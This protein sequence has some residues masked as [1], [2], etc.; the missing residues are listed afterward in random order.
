MYDLER[1]DRIIEILKEKNSISVNKLANILF[2][3]GATIRRDLS[4]MEQKGLVVRTFGAVILNPNPS[5]RETSFELREKTNV[6]EKRLLC[7]KA[8]DMIIDNTSIFFD[9]STTLL[10]IVPYLNNFSNL[11]IITNGLFIAN[12]II[13]KTKHRVIICGGEI[14]ANTNSIL[15]AIAYD[16]LNNFHVDLSIVSTAGVVLKKD[17][18]FSESTVD[19]AKIK[20]ILAKNA[21]KV[22]CLVDATKINTNSLYKSIELGDVDVIIS[23]YELTKEEKE[24]LENNNILYVN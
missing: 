14:Q 16:S 13:T 10:H 3:S 19:S 7:Q 24:L 8:A 18:G 2:V 22:I 11:T 5:N 23:T 17:E 21:Q 20:N 12:E 15:G 6:V 1:Q 9:S 4:K